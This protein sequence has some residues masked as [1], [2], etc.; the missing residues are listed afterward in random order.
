MSKS[1]E[2]SKTGIK[3]N[4]DNIPLLENSILLA[5]EIGRL[6]ELVANFEKYKKL[7]V[8][9]E[10]EIPSSILKKVKT[11]RNLLDSGIAPK[12][13]AKVFELSETV[14]RENGVKSTGSEIIRNDGEFGIFVS[15]NASPEIA[16]KMNGMLSEKLASLKDFIVYQ[17]TL[18]YR[19]ATQA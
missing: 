14:L 8:N 1:W 15:T 11:A 12:E 6:P 3:L 10:T 13:V 9:Q 16:A 19:P 17:F 7:M 18:V 4:K 5:Y 2:L